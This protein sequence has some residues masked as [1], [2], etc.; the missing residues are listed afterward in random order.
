MTWVSGDDETVTVTI[1]S[2]AAGVV[3]GFLPVADAAA[4][5]D[6]QPEQLVEEAQ[7]WAVASSL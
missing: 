1:C 6:L 4:L 3:P 7:A 2:D 5:V